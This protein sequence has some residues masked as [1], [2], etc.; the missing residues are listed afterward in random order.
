[1]VFNCAG[2]IIKLQLRLYTHLLCTRIYLPRY[3]IHPHGKSQTNAT[4]IEI[5]SLQKLLF[6]IFKI[7]DALVLPIASY[8]CQIWLPQTKF[9]MA[10]SA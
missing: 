9:M 2:R 8:G 6:V 1:M 3:K 4:E 10:F 5:K 7:F